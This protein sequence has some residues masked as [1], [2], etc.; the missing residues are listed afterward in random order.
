MIGSSSKNKMLYWDNEQ[1][2]TNCI[3][4]FQ[5]ICHQDLT[6]PKGLISGSKSKFLYSRYKVLV[7]FLYC[8][9]TRDFTGLWNSESPKTGFN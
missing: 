6:Q 1:V 8:V 9:G 7:T 3:A 2:N 4:N 5:G